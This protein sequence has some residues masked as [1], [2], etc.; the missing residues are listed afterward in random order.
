S[1]ENMGASPATSNAVSLIVALPQTTTSVIALDASSPLATGMDIAV[2]EP[3]PA[4]SDPPEQLSLL[5][6]GLV[7]QATQSCTLAAPPLVL[8]RPASGSATY[9]LCVLGTA[10]DQ[11]AQVTFSSPEAPDLTAA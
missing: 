3:T 8:A 2:V 11:V 1:V 7:D 10:L 9:R 5:E 4:G 6:I